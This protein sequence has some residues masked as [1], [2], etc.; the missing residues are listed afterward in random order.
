MI[1]RLLTLLTALGAVGFCTALE[2]T[3]LHQ[4]E[5]S[6]E[7]VFG[8]EFSTEKIRISFAPAGGHAQGLATINGDTSYRLLMESYYTLCAVHTEAPPWSYEDYRKTI[9]TE[10]GNQSIVRSDLDWYNWLEIKFWCWEDMQRPTLLELDAYHYH[11]DVDILAKAVEHVRRAATDTLL[12]RFNVT[13][14]ERPLVSVAGPNFMWTTEP[15]DCEG[16]FDPSCDSPCDAYRESWRH[17][18]DM[19]LS[20]AVLRAGFRRDLANNVDTIASNHGDQNHTCP[21]A[22]ASYAAF[23]DPEFPVEADVTTS[24]LAG[25]SQIQHEV[26]PAVV[27]ELTNATLSLWA[28]QKCSIWSPWHTFYQFGARQQFGDYPG[29]MYNPEADVWSNIVARIQV[30]R[31]FLR[32]PYHESLDVYLTGDAWNSDMIDAF[33]EY[34]ANHD[35]TTMNM[36]WR[37]SF[38][39]SDG[40]ATIARE[41]LD[42]YRL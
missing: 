31:E 27:V 7:P 26:R 1:M 4:R 39:A 13:M 36:V 17:V 29:Y 41:M 33:E 34:Q 11:R 20:D 22:P 10:Y 25:S 5:L 16:N 40:A 23:W 32:H 12:H 28:Q 18:F 8:I 9:T 2:A 42:P 6:G 19:K 15:E 21:I 30:L 38:S 3:E 37:D 24:R 35:Y 14:P